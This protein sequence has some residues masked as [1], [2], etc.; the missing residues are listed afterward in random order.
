MLEVDRAREAFEQRRAAA[1]DHRRDDDRQLVDE[2]GVERLP[3]VVPA[4]HDVDVL[5]AG[6]LHRPSNRV[7]H[8]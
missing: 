4:A 5:V 2:P 1:E 8:A 6:S 3:Y 7:L